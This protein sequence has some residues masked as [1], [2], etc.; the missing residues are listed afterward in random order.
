MH[1]DVVGVPSRVSMP[2]IPAKHILSFFNI[3]VGLFEIQRGG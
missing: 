2:P 1:N 3:T